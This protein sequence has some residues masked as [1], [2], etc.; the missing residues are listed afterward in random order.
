MNELR[1][2]LLAY[3][4]AED[5]PLRLMRLAARARVDQPRL[6][7][8]ELLDPLL[9]DVPAEQAAAAPARLA[10]LKMRF[11]TILDDD[12]PNMLRH[13]PDPPV[14]FFY[15][16]ELQA[17]HR[18][19]ISVVG[20]RSCTL[21]GRQTAKKLAAELAEL[22]FVIVSGLAYGIDASAHEAALEVGGRTAAVLGSGLDRMYPRVHRE[23]A[24][25]IAQGGGAVISE[26]APGAP[27]KPHHF[28]IRNRLIS[29]LS[30]A[31]VVVEAKAKSGSL[32]TARHCLEQGRELFAVPGPIHHATSVGVNRLIDDGEARA[33][34][35][36]ASVL[37]QL[38]PLIGM[39]TD[40]QRALGAEIADPLARRVYAR[41]DAFDPTPLDV[42]VN[43]LATE[44][45][46]VLA[47]LAELE[48]QRYVERLPGQLFVRNPIA[49]P[50]DEGAEKTRL[51]R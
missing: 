29:G 14:A 40:H 35:S 20:A 51:P 43:D 15:A 6:Q 46:A 37:E 17:L 47:K 50:P 33:L 21:Y 2:R 44:T 5:G 32:I 11:V 8:R 41:L 31:V 30:H 18:P 16:G 27:P 13:I 9:A 45:G 24:L 38:Q 3:C 36:T 49:A 7:W 48:T 42:L 4:L 12:F 1:H 19:C 22:G 10:S 26:L 39:A 34:L 28:P 25:E 23:L